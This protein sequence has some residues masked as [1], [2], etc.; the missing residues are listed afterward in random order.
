MGIQEIRVRSFHMGGTA[1]GD[2]RL[3]RA[4]RRAHFTYE[5]GSAPGP[6]EASRE[7]LVELIEALERDGRAVPPE[8]REA[9]QELD[10]PG[11]TRKPQSPI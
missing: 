5:P 2:Q 6:M 4:E 9:I 1:V 7:S 10:S 3:D 11:S 8:F